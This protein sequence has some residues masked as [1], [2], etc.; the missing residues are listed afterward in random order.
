MNYKFTNFTFRRFVEGKAAP[1]SI[2][3]ENQQL[4]ALGD[5]CAY[6]GAAGKL[7]WE[8]I[9]P[10]ALGGPDSIDNMVRACAPCNLEK[11]ARDPYQWYLGKNSDSIPRLVLGK[12]LKV[13]FEEYAI[14]DLL[15][16]TEFMKSHAIERVN[17]SSIFRMQNVYVKKSAVQP[18][19]QADPRTAGGL[20]WP[21][22]VCC[23][24]PSPASVT[25]R[26]A[27]IRNA[28]R[29]PD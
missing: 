23:H 19:A 11:G 24:V 5:V 10:V 21:L 1:S 14:R 26:A 15:D 6:C 27:L 9:I 25:G 8:H 16:S 3:T 13:A 7:H 4:F 12:F 18:I 17:L 29:P 22:S 20:P 28:A 2:L